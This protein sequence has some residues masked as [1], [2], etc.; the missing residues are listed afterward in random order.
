MLLENHIKTQLPSI[1]RYQQELPTISYI[2]KRVESKRSLTES[3]H[4]F[5]TKNIAILFTMIDL[6]I[7]RTKI[8]ILYQYILL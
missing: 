4:I 5:E 7:R 6:N 2:D 3:N 1:S 8:R